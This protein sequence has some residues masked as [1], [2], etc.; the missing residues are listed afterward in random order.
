[1]KYEIDIDLGP[2]SDEW[3]PVAF[4]HPCHKGD[5]WVDTFGDVERI[6]KGIC[7]PR[8]IV[9][10]RWHWPEWLTAEWIA[11]DF[12]GKWYGYANEPEIMGNGVMAW[13][14]NG[15]VCNLSFTTFTPPPCTDWT[16]SKR[17]NPNSKATT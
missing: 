9:R 6:D 10:R 12:T 17:R 1:M 14:G 2:L 13:W 15:G 4:R 3:E 5:A 8:L 16:Q 7:G 11:M